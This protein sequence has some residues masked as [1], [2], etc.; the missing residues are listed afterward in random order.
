MLF[1]FKYNEIIKAE[2]FV[3]WLVFKFFKTFIMKKQFHIICTGDN[4]I[5]K[6]N[7]MVKQHKCE[8]LHSG[9]MYFYIKYLLTQK[10]FI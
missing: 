8:L 1:F 7:I 3:F 10:L 6:T 2:N 4:N 5:Y 9:Y